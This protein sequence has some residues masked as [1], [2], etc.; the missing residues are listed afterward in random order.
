MPQWEVQKGVPQPAS[1]VQ[2]LPA[3]TCTRLRQLRTL[4]VDLDMNQP[5]HSYRPTPRH[6]SISVPLQCGN[7][8]ENGGK[9]P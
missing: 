2:G 9:S 3:G 1:S 8:L 5:F 4:V 7:R 6:R